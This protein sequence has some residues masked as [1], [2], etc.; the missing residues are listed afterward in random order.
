MASD[1]VTGV[2]EISYFIVKDLIPSIGQ[3][4]DLY[5]KFKD[6]KLYVGFSTE[7]D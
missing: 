1:T 4:A 7:I 2:P 3:N 6:V 5:S